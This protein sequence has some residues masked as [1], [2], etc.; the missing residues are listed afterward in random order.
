M[1]KFLI[2]NLLIAG[3]LFSVAAVAQ[4][5]FPLDGTWRGEHAA[6][7]GAPSTVVMIMQW[8]GK[9]VAG[10]INPGPT[11]IDFNGAQLDPDGWKVHLAAT[12]AKGKP[13]TFEGVLS[14]LGKYSR[15]I[16]GT[17]TQDG[18]TH[19]IRFVRE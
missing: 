11:G 14:D 19:D 6:A 18:Q 8:D 15:V 17:W 10:T 2:S 1:R 7:K 9:Q 3:W 4:E 12:D 13:V 5:G 16:T